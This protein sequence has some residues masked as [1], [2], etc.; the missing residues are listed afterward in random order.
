MKKNKYH[1]GEEVIDYEG[2][3]Y[4]VIVIVGK[5]TIIL[6]AL[7]DLTSGEIV[8]KYEHEICGL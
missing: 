6:Y 4:K 7:K 8:V 2:K 3:H 5:T 1:I